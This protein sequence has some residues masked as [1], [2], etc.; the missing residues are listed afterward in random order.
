MVGF[1]W[2]VALQAVVR[3]PKTNRSTPKWG[4]KP[5]APMVD[6]AT[7]DCS[8]TCGVPYLSLRLG[9]VVFFWGQGWWGNQIAQRLVL[10]CIFC[11]WKCLCSANST[12]YMLE[13]AEYIHIYIYYKQAVYME[14]QDDRL[15]EMAIWVAWCDM[16]GV[17]NVWDATHT[18]EIAAIGSQRM[19]VSGVHGTSRPHLCEFTGCILF[20]MFPFPKIGRM[21]PQRN[22]RRK[23]NLK[24]GRRL[25]CLWSTPNQ[26]WLRYVV[27]GWWANHTKTHIM[28]SFAS[29]SFLLI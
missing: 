8:S 23:R 29:S 26:A 7:W 2:Y 16:D 22:P 9:V 1:I 17:I 20:H 18:P 5:T 27:M 13:Y 14:E 28:T 10:L 21:V 19:C 12:C 25:V 6:V 4:L 11:F 3:R 15:H 24:T